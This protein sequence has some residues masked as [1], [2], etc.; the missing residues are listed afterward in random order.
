M[1]DVFAGGRMAAVTAHHVDT[2]GRV[3]LAVGGGSPLATVAAREIGPV[4]VLVRAARVHS[5]RCPDR[6]RSR[7]ELLGRMTPE[8]DGDGLTLTVEP[9][10]VSLDEMVVSV[11][12][13]RRAV[14]DPLAGIEADDLTRLVGRPED[15]L[16][17]CTLL[18]ATA[19]AGAKTVVP[20]GLDRYGLTLQV[21][22][23]SGTAEHR[24]AFPHDVAGPDSL[25][26]ALRGLLA[27]DR[28]RRA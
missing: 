20:V 19:T 12:R 4:A 2:G 13:Y 25:H 8:V 1:L 22:G 9:T 23:A 16:R 26:Q 21:T 5:A 7:V 10:H 28:A 14:P 27:A 18:G 24:L 17:L 15:L 6:V 11:R 3:V